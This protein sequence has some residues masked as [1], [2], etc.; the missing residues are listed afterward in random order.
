MTAA[1]KREAVVTPGIED[2]EKTYR[3]IGRFM[4]AFSQ[5]ELLIR[6]HL[7]EQI[8]LSSQYFF[9]IVQSY[10]LGVLCTVAIEVFKRG[11][12]KENATR[13]ENLINRFRKLTEARNRVAHRVWLPHKDGGTL[14]YTPRGTFK[15]D[16][17]V[18]QAEELEKLADRAFTLCVE[19]DQAF[20]SSE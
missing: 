6:H 1:E 15:P 9:P 10:D 8:G 20:F 11:R 16:L 13:I 19:L 18:K 4:F 5:V 12:E 14:H 7:G 2:S 17:L 3:A